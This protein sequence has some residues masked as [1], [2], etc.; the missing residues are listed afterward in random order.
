MTP[1]E[2]FFNFCQIGNT[3]GNHTIFGFCYD[4][5]VLFMCVVSTNIHKFLLFD[6]YASLLLENFEV[7]VTF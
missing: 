6:F 5:L 7:A 4:S 1:T 2:F 3:S